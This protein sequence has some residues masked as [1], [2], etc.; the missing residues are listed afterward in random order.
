M[1]L[2][3]AVT[4]VCMEIGGSKWP[5]LDGRGKLCY[6]DPE[7]APRKISSRRSRGSALRG[8]VAASLSQHTVAAILECIARNQM[9]PASH[10]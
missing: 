4:G 7:I 9:S 6:I 10:S 1:E 5:L 8:D 3:V 2:D